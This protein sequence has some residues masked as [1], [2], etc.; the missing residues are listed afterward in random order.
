MLTMPY[1]MMSLIL[2]GLRLQHTTTRLFSICSLGTNLTS[3]LITFGGAETQV[4]TG[5]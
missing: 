1:D 4:H 5:S 3:P 2:A